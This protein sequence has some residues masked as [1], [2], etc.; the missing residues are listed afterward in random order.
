MFAYSP[1]EE[2]NRA[3]R[4]SKP[5]AIRIENALPAIVSKAQFE[6]VQRIMDEKKQ[7]GK[8]A[9]YLCSGLVYCFCGAKMHGASPTRKG[10]VYR[11]YTC[12]AKCGFGSVDMDD[13]DNAAIAYLKT[14]LSA[15][16]QKKI[17]AALRAY[18]TTES[19]RAKDFNAAIKKKVSDK[20]AEYDVLMANL[21]AGQLPPDVITDI[22][23]RMKNFKDEMDALRETDPPKD[24][25]TE[26]TQTWL[27]SLKHAPD[28]KTINLLVERIDV[29]SKT[30]FVVSSTLQSV[31]GETGCGGG[32]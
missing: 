29:K 4:R 30:D 25:T 26:Q 23:R 20:Q 6:E 32:I 8:K 7:V 15:G 28:E 13:V 14:L 3:E 2:K 16:N 27:N 17:A 21:S 31:L 22:G 19:D 24:Y 11:K 10:H 18:Q 9:G 1:T 5:N 12:S